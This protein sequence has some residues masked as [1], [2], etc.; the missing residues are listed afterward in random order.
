MSNNYILIKKGV[1]LQW[2]FGVGVAVGISR[3][4]F[5]LHKHIP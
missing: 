4:T 2:K 5:I 3:I 1:L